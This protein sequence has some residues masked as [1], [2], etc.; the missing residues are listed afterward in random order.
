MALLDF[1][2]R[3]KRVIRCY[4][5]NA[6]TT[7][8]EAKA[9]DGTNYCP[10]CYQ[11]IQA[12]RNRQKDAGSG[13]RSYD[14][15]YGKGGGSTKPVKPEKPVKPVKPVTP[16]HN[17]GECPAQLRDIKKVLT[18]TNTH[19]K[20]NHVQ[21]QWEIVAGFSGNSAK[22]ELKFI[23]KEGDN[24]LALRIF[25]LF[26]IDRSSWYKVY[27]VLNKYQD[28]YRFLRFTLDTDGDINVE[29]DVPNCTQDA[30]MIAV[31][32]IL[33]IGQI[34]DD[35]YPELRRIAYS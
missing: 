13:G 23:C 30:G 11:R 8:A 14:D 19:F 21:D 16:S 29:Y 25:G 35:V 9:I 33:R 32:M 2:S 22:Y 10:T 18:D 24:S 3:D 6:P 34:L 12:A 27:P 17:S 26:N 20:E 28:T 4:R 15:K 31:E 5:C 1:M 7:A